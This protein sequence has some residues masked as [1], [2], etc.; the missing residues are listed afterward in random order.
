MM[1]CIRIPPVTSIQSLHAELGG[2][3]HHDLDV[4]SAIVP[5]QSATN[6]AAEIPKAKARKKINQTHRPT[7]LF[8]ATPPPQIQR[9]ILDRHKP[10]PLIQRPP[11]N[12][13]LQIALQPALIRDAQSPIEQH[14]A[15]P[16]P[17]VLRVRDERIQR[18]E[19]ARA[20]DLPLSRIKQIEKR[21]PHLGVALGVRRGRREILVDVLLGPRAGG[22]VGRE[23]QGEARP[24][25]D[26]PRCGVDALG[27]EDAFV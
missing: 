14:A 18:H 6:Q 15:G 24:R 20:H 12:T 9:D 22:R 5:S 17:M 4:T 11:H 13:R 21:I 27:E 19:L 7:N 2:R 1:L 26:G 10:I 16:T 8:V 25:D 23:V 3:S